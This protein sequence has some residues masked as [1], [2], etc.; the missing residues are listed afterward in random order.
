MK[1]RWVIMDGVIKE[2][3]RNY[4]CP[5]EGSWFCLMGHW[6]A[7]CCLLSQEGGN[8]RRHWAKVL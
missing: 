5:G 2:N 7:T 6:G 1:G 3:S 8:R 4:G